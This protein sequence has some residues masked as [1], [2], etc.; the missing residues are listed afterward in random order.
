[1]QRKCPNGNRAQYRSF[2]RKRSSLWSWWR[3]MRKGPIRST[4]SFSGGQHSHNITITIITFG[5][6]LIKKEK[7]TA[8]TV[9]FQPIRRRLDAGQ[10]VC[11]ASEISRDPSTSSQWEPR[12]VQSGQFGQRMIVRP[13]CLH[14]HIFSSFSRTQTNKHTNAN[15][16]LNMRKWWSR[17][18]YG[19]CAVGSGS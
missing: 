1:M 7:R 15:D 2:R 19:V 9:P 17:K 11:G 3:R 13:L 8:A 5:I 14:I 16:S 6:I 18:F 10:K 12:S 4:S